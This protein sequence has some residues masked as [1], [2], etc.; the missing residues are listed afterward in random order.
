MTVS[1]MFSHRLISRII[2]E[3]I[4]SP[5]P[6]FGSVAELRDVGMLQSWDVGRRNEKSSLKV[7]DLWVFDGWKDC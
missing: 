6:K 2:A 7:Q 4:S 1:M 5:G 3:I